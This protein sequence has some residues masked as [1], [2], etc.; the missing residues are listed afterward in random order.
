MQ[1]ELKDLGICLQKLIKDSG[2]TLDTISK[3]SGVS[4][5]TL[6][7]ASRNERGMQPQTAR[8]LN[9]YFKVPYFV[10]YQDKDGTLIPSPK[11]VNKSA[12]IYNVGDTVMSYYDHEYYNVQE[13]KYIKYDWHYYIGNEWVAEEYLELA[14]VVKANIE[15]PVTPTPTPTPMELTEDH[16]M[17]QH[18]LTL[19]SKQNDSINS[20]STTLEYILSMINGLTEKNSKPTLF[21]LVDKIL[22]LLRG[23]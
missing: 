18:I 9:K 5:A 21:T 12:N 16:P 11:Q 17:V 6:S 1:L 23:E 7:R 8:K 22:D 20:I 19:I 2:K 10:G 14:P 3:E 15:E 13:I 4:L